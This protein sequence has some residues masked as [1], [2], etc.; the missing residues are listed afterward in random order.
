MCGVGVGIT[1]RFNASSEFLGSNGADSKFSH[2]SDNF[3]RV[4]SQQ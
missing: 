1:L 4:I 2:K 3:V